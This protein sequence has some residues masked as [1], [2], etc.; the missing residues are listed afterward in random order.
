MLV[1][2]SKVLVLIVLIKIVFFVYVFRADYWRSLDDV[3]V[4]R[5]IYPGFLALNRHTAAA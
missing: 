2:S 1:A 4:F 5:S 3:F